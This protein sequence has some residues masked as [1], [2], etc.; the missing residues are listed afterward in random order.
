MEVEKLLNGLI[1]IEISEDE[2]KTKGGIHIEKNAEDSYRIGIVRKE[3][4]S[5]IDKF[6]NSTTH[7]VSVGD[8]VMFDKFCVRQTQEEN[9][10]LV[11]EKD[12]WAI[13]E[14]GKEENAN[15]NT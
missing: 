11:E 7:E 13:L 15:K 1:L 12:I 4:F 5:Y 14:F 3:E 10:F 9:L 6:G 2:T 8:K